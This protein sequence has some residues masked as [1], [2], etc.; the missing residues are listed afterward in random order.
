MLQY[1]FVILAINFAQLDRNFNRTS[2]YASDRDELVRLLPDAAPGAEKAGVLWRISRDWLLVGQ[3]ES[4]RESKRACFAE[5]IRYAEMAIHENPNDPQGYMWHCANL[6]RDAQTR[7]TMSQAK[8]V[9]K[10]IADLTT[11]L[12]RLGRTDCSEAWQ[13]ISEI[14]WAH[15]FKS[16]DSAVN[17]ARK[18][19]L[20]IPRDELR[21]T[22]LTH[23]SDI[24]YQRNW[25]A[26]KRAAEALESTR[27]MS[28]AGKSNIEWFSY[29]DGAPAENLAA[30]WTNAR[31]GEISDRDEAKAVAAYAQR[32]FR[33]CPAP[34]PIDINDI[35]ILINLQKKWQ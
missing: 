12:D 15:P 1:L 14:W 11:I 8:I 10:L 3:E 29:F 19:A 6:G 22:T 18:A 35:K 34:S 13:A 17:F 32:I 28:A 16:S 7:S 26:E 4:D 25:S 9:S 23:L 33:E 20:T 24:L 27:K 30:P 31:I 5:G 21:I 2:D